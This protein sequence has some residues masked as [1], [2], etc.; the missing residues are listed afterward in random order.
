M[1]RRLGF[2]LFRG[3]NRIL[4]DVLRC[5]RWFS[6]YRCARRCRCFHNV[7][8]RSLRS[9]DGEHRSTLFGYYR[10]LLRL[11]HYAT[12]FFVNTN[13]WPNLRLLLLLLLLLLRVPLS[14]HRHSG[15]RDLA[16]HRTLCRWLLRQNIRCLRHW[17]TCLE[18]I[19]LIRSRNAG[20][21]HGDSRHHHLLESLQ[22]SLLLLRRWIHLHRRGRTRG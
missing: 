20:V 13:T 17:R 16:W 12:S 18:L 3:F 7:M 11:F 10:H 14:G 4:Y 2:W 19:I 15:P 22:S 5:R 9:S 6:R 1:Q 21:G 8:N